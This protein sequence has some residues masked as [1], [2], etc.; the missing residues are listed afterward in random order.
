MIMW[1]D[2]LA[3]LIKAAG[4]RADVLWKLDVRRGQL[5]QAETPDKRIKLTTIKSKPNNIQLR[6]SHRNPSPSINVSSATQLPNRQNSHNQS[7]QV[8]SAFGTQTSM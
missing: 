8:R 1:K 4:S 2:Q 3:E 5:K 7:H 6:L